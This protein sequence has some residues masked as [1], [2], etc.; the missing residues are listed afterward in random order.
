[1]NISNKSVTVRVP[2]KLFFA[3]EYAVTRPNGLA[4]VTTIETDFAV[5]IS[6]SEGKS[7]LHTNVNLH[8]F[9]FTLSHISF[10]KENAWNFA[11]TALL[12]TLSA[13]IRNLS[14][15][16][17]EICVEIQSEMG[18]GEQKKGY[19]SSA[20]VVCGMVNA[21]NEYFGLELALEERFEIA[22]ATH[23][24]VQGSGSMGDIA[25]I[26]YGGSV[27][28]Q[29][30]HRIIPVEIP[31]KTYVLQTGKSAKTSE[32]L[33]IELSEDFFVASDELVIEIATAIDIND[34]EL[35][36]EKL[37]ENQLLLLKN[38]PDGYMTYKLSV[39]LNLV[40]SHPELAGKISGAGFGENI[41]I[42]AK[43]DENIDKLRERLKNYEIELI[44]SKISMRNK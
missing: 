5:R 10:D 1:M 7:R 11:L 40:N 8:D 12:K 19:G 15:L 27:F 9:E 41:I 28:Y 20:S 18:F 33:K 3:G 43:S 30:H 16:T 35:F 32:K 34:F 29:N 17:E 26:M 23:F 4:L 44:E 21:V 42:F 39:G 24:E 38:I 13:Q 22:A 6:K 14:A 37:L 31:W 25:A 2:G 36:K